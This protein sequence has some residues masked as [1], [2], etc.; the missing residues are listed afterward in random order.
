LDY[1]GSK[2]GRRYR[3]P[4]PDLDYEVERENLLKQIK[5]AAQKEAKDLE[6]DVR[7]YGEMI[8][9]NFEEVKKLGCGGLGNLL[10]DIK[11]KRKSRVEKFKAAFERDK[12]R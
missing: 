1:I 10:Q 3:G 7:A 4:K 5:Q 12:W 8:L 9:R 2:A 6:P 11:E